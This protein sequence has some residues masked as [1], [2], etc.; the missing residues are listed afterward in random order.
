MAF[1]AKYPVTPF[2]DPKTGMPTEAWHQFLLTIGTPATVAP[3]STTAAASLASVIQPVAVAATVQS[4]FPP[5]VAP[6][7][8]L[9]AP[10]AVIPNFRVRCVIP[11]TGAATQLDMYYQE[12]S[13][14]SMIDPNGWIH[15]ATVG[16]LSSPPFTPNSLVD[17]VVSNPPPTP[18]DKQVFAI[19]TVS[20]SGGVSSPSAIS[21]GLTWPPNGQYLADPVAPVLLA[22]LD[23]NGNV[24]KIRVTMSFNQNSGTMPDGIAVM[25]SITDSPN[26]IGILLDSGNDLELGNA[27]INAH[28]TLNVLAGSSAG[29]IINTTTVQPNDTS[30]GMMSRFWAQFN[31]S[32][33]RKVTGITPTSFLFNP[34]FDVLPIAG[35]T[36][37]WVEMSWYDDR[38]IDGNDTY[39]APGESYRLGCVV[40]GSNYE[41]LSWGRVYQDG[42]SN[43]HVDGCVRGLEGTLPLNLT[44]QTM[45][46]FPAPGAGTIIIAV[47]ALA[48]TISPNGDWSGQTEANITVPAGWV[49]SLSCCTFK[50][51]LGKIIRSNIVPMTYGGQF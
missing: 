40:E 1:P 10:G 39:G 13:Q 14:L 9:L 15:G 6:T 49:G 19:F 34:P 25:Y 11:T 35:E 8:V 5:L 46:Y 29:E 43:F 7:F 30:Y 20:N 28:G 47:P 21:L 37:N 22:S 12:A 23:V 50:K 16:S 4:Q 41:V 24:T 3:A 38:T 36:L 17:I 33:W 27:I 45:H 26:Q 32:Q 48:F 31:S 42:V 2:L 44:G 51:V 18:I